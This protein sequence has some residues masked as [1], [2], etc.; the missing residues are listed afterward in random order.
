MVNKNFITIKDYSA[1]NAIWNGNELYM[2]ATKPLSITGN[3]VIEAKIKNFQ[4]IDVSLDSNY[5]EN[6]DRRKSYV[7]YGGFANP[8]LKVTCV[9]N[10]TIITPTFTYNDSTKYVF[11]PS[12]LYELILQPRTVY[13]NDEFLIRDL[14]SAS[15]GS[16]P[17][18]Y[19]S[20]GIPVVLNS[21][22]INPSVEGKEV[23]MELGFLED[24]EI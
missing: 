12:K 5:Q 8:E 11:T 4:N 22:N 17:Q 13:I 20:K 19:S 16:S 7:S 1:S 14:L 18:V 6:F 2:F 23:I 24:K 10:P 15:E 3:Q 21:W 9:Y